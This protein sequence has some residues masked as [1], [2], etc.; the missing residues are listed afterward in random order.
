MRRRALAA[1]RHSST[2]APPGN[3]VGRAAFLSAAPVRGT[4]GFLQG[5]PQAARPVTPVQ[6]AGSGIRAFLYVAA[7][8]N[9]VAAALV[10]VLVRV[11]PHA[12]GLEPM[13]GGQL[14]YADLVALLVAGFGVGYALAGRD[15]ARYWTFLALGAALKSGV[16][17]L[18]LA[19]FAAGQSALLIVLLAAGDFCFAVL[20]VLILRRLRAS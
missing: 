15:L 2:A 8:F 20:F 7:S 1:R 3:S 19:Y 12:H 9:F 6:P 17:L 4:P 14:F 10:V 5:G 13:R 11:A 16:A 18:V